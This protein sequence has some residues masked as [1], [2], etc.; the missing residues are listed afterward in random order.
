[1]QVKARNLLVQL[2]TKV[3]SKILPIPDPEGE[4]QY[5]DECCSHNSSRTKR[6]SATDGFSG[7]PWTLATYMVEGGSSKTFNKIK[8]MMYAEPQALHLLLDKVADS[9]ILY[10]NAQIKAGAQAVMVFDTW[11]VY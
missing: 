6:R 2:K 5:V 1:M 3:R 10:L 9:V 4:L 11:G 8:K 7:S